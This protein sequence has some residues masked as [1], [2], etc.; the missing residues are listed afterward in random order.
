LKGKGGY[1]NK[2]L[3]GLLV[4]GLLVGSMVGSVFADGNGND[5]CYLGN[6]AGHGEGNEH[7]IE[8]V[9]QEAWDEYVAKVNSTDTG[10]II[11]RQNDKLYKIYWDR[12]FNHK[13]DDNHQIEVI[14]FTPATQLSEEEMEEIEF[15]KNKED[16]PFLPEITVPTGDLAIGG[17]VLLGASSLIALLINNKKRK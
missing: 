4:V 17:T 3:R 13:K 10:V 8:N 5:G 15:N 9:N 16:M 14:H 6:V 1:M 2:K 11:E 7:K 12:D